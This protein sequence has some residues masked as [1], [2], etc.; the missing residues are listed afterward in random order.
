MQIDM[1][2]NSVQYTLICFD[3]Y[4]FPSKS[5]FPCHLNEQIKEVRVEFV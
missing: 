1:N 5:M 2:C 3:I 4:K